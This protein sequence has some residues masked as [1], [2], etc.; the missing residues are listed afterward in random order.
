V[1]KQKVFFISGHPGAGKTQLV[2]TRAIEQASKG[3]KTCIV[4]ETTQLI[5]ETKASC[6]EK[7]S[8]LNPVKRDF[9]IS[10]FYKESNDHIETGQ[11]SVVS[12]IETSFTK[13]PFN[14]GTITLFTHKSLIVGHNRF[15][16]QSQ[17]RL[18][19]DEVPKAVEQSTKCLPRNYV[20]LRELFDTEESVKGFYKLTL[21]DSVEARRTLR[22]KGGDDIDK[23]FQDLLERASGPYDLFIKAAHWDDITEAKSKKGCEGYLTFIAILKPSLFGRFHEPTIMSA[24]FENS[25]LF[26]LWTNRYNVE[27]APSRLALDAR[28][29]LTHENPYLVKV[30]WLFET[31]P[32]LTT[33]EKNI[34]IEG[35]SGAAINQLIKICKDYFGQQKVLFSV[36]K[37][38]Q[39]LIPSHYDS[40]PCNS[41][42]RNK[43]SDH[44]R[45]VSLK[46]SNFS[47]VTIE[48]L[49]ALGV[50]Q[51]VIFNHS[52]E[53]AHQELLR[54]AAR[55]RDFEGTIEVV[56]ASKQ[57]ATAL[58]PRFSRYE[59][60]G[61]LPG[62][63]SPIF[64]ESRGRPSSAN[65]KSA[66]ERQAKYRRQQLEDIRRQEIQKQLSLN[67]EVETYFAGQFSNDNSFNSSNKRF[68]VT[69]LTESFNRPIFV[70][71]FTKVEEAAVMEPWRFT[72]E[73][74]LVSMLI[75]CSTVEFKNKK[76]N[77][78]ISP[79]TFGDILNIHGNRQASRLNVLFAWG[80]Y[81]DIDDGNLT[82]E[83]FTN[84]FGEY[85][86]YLYNTFSE[87]NRFRVILP[88]ST[89][90]TDYAYKD[91]A[92]SLRVLVEQ[93][94]YGFTRPSRN[95]KGLSNTH[96]IDTSKLSA[97]SKMYLPCRAKTGESDSFFI[98]HPGKALDVMWFMENPLHNEDPRPHGSKGCLKA[99]ASEIVAG[100]P[101]IISH[102]DK[103]DQMGL[104]DEVQQYVKQLGY[105]PSSAKL[106]SEAIVSY[107]ETTPGQGK[108][109]N[110][111]YRCAKQFKFIGVNR[112]HAQLL[113]AV[114]D[115]DC[116]R[117]SSGER[118]YL[119]N[120]FWG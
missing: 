18:F 94:R 93:S 72:N 35:Q 70:Q 82:P 118:E 38:Y 79:A 4:Q 46:A 81:L 65:A 90:L 33:F 73:D 77:S 111:Y 31:R 74:A 3:I 55:R 9:K 80:I 88:T 67:H 5:S 40:L 86:F 104:Q 106:I 57:T 11:G 99:R 17:W 95:S 30:F 109:N 83:I 13:T 108:R 28:L 64:K 97:A 63:S 76:E 10:A 116:S 89:Y 42:G 110:A 27:F 51:E 62:L 1:R 85:R 48:L 91:I 47:P 8:A 75:N 26:W 102:V 25:L 53:E 84:I 2:L 44:I 15:S 71:P 29:P 119:L 66:S 115:R 98:S 103:W 32:S 23:V 60:A 20:Q 6:E 113:L 36:N 49:R 78:L 21:K 120:N 100:T 50:P 41:K 39:S 96:G 117:Q 58:A 45:F 107:W 52:V 34:D 14:R 43:F 87:G 68:S 101:S 16:N 22:N 12:A 24:N 105:P 19:I 112:E 114:A 92:L 54:T 59:L 61:L 7:R 37:V 56:F 69:N